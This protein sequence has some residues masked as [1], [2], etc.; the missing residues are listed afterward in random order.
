[1]LTDWKV[2]YWVK[3]SVF[4]KLIYIFNAIPNMI[5]K[6]FLMKLNNLTLNIYMETQA[7]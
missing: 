2:Q 7:T 5:S 4:P 3:A 1:M 6:E